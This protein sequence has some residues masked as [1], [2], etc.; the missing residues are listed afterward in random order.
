MNSD[1]PYWPDGFFAELLGLAEAEDLQ[2]GLDAPRLI[3][4]YQR[5]AEELT[6][7][8]IENPGRALA[9]E[10]DQRAA[11]ET[12]LAARWGRSL[13][14]FK[15]T[16]EQALEAGRWINTRWRPRAAARQDQRFEA[17]IRLHGR[18][19][20]T[21]NEVQV[22]LRA[23]YS[24]GAFARWRT[25]HEIW[26]VASVLSDHDQEVSRRYLVHDA[27][28]SMKGQEEYEQTWE[29]LGFEPP[30]WTSTERDEL[31]VSLRNEFGEPFLRDYGWA[32]PLFGDHAPRFR[33]IQELAALDHWR[34]YYR[35]ASHGTHANPKGISW[36]IQDSE[37]LTWSGLDRRTRA[38]LIPHS[39]RSSHSPT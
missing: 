13:D 25:I 38:S 24:T 26:V 12:Q 7:P 31:R 35:M 6:W 23:G 33:Q 8:V 28:E 4:M 11:F 15:L 18:A 2:D 39:A 29:A 14:L 27:V 37:V 34:G 10:R 32:A 20:M 36:N 9:E 21:A 30:D 5:S 19:V 1:D 22:L 3:E 16:V 17:L